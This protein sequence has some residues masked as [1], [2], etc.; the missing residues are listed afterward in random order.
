[1]P[2]NS[3]KL[4]AHDPRPVTLEWKGMWKNMQVGFDG[5]PLGVIPD[6]KALKAGQEFKLPD[7]ST[8][9]V[10][11]KTGFQT[12]L[13]VMRDGKPLPGSG[14]DPASR[15]KVAQGVIWFVGGLTLILGVVAEV[16]QVRLLL[17]LGMGWIAAGVGVVFGVLG[18]FVGKRSMIAL[19]LATGLLLVDTV[20]TLMA[21]TGAG[22]F[23]SGAVF[24]RV[25]L[26]IA[27]FQGFGAI[28]AL[29]AADARK[30]QADAF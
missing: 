27:L 22:R 19:G 15:V 30:D 9:S 12:E 14:G 28:K 18:Y 11:L 6:A 20:L 4:S 26:L 29:K 24:V 23:P 17:E 13:Q 2:K 21:T 7:G 10:K 3:F 25:F 16:A 5:Q 8:L 1:M